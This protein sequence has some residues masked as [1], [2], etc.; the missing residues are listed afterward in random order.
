MAT[1]N[2]I[3]T[4]HATLVANVVDTV[5][6]TG[7]PRV[8]VRIVNRNAVAPI[9]VRLDGVDPVS[10][11]DETYGIALSTEKEITVPN[12]NVIQ[13]RL[14]STGAAAYSVEAI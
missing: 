8:T 6:I 14:I 12:I 7:V 11:A 3:N 10:G 13:V 1:F 9:F 4:K 2:A 5:N